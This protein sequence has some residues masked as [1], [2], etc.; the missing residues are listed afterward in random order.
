VDLRLTPLGQPLLGDR[1]GHEQQPDQCAAHTRARQKEV[2]EI[3]GCHA[4]I[5]A[6]AHDVRNLAS[7]VMDHGSSAHRQDGYALRMDWGPSGGRAIAAG[8][9]V[10]V[11]VD[12]LSF[13]TTLTVAADRGTVVYPFRWRDRSAAR[14]AEEH[15]AVLAVGRS[16]ASG[17]EVSLSPRSV[18]DASDL[19]RL[20]LPSP[21][22]AT[23]SVELASVTPTVV[24]VSLRN[25]AAAAAW[26][27]QR[28]EVNP[29]MRVAVV[30]AG[31]RWP[32]GTLRPA[33]EDQWGA[34]ALVTSLVAGGWSAP[35]PEACAA[36]AA[37][38]AVGRG[39]RGALHRCV[40]GRELI[41]AGYRDDVDIAE[42]LDR[43]RSVPVLDGDA[44]VP[45]SSAPAP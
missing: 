41:S 9:D 18:R 27:L 21:N 1:D 12:V 31:E 35:S 8:C 14:F 11:V 29:G 44:F 38:D 2:A 22:G 25:R 19:S 42:E 5:F 36:V 17:R 32:D 39:V 37:F 3:V 13:T 10:A 34:G 40:S 7:R 16:K 24:G 20:V 26:L 15:G 4:R 23:V 6:Q 43:S 30:A 45:V 33:V 28:R